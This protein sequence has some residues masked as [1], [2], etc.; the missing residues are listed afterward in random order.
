MIRLNFVF[1]VFLS[2]FKSMHEEPRE[3]EQSEQKN[4]LFLNKKKC[5]FYFPIIK[6]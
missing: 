6:K 2:K 4:F 1:V 3:K 5:L